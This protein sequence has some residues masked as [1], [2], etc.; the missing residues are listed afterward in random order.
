[1]CVHAL[2]S[3]AQSQFSMAF[4][5]ATQGSTHILPRQQYQWFAHGF[6]AQ[7]VQTYSIL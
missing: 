1:M 2:F 5:G 6:D 7:P 4:K 3:Q